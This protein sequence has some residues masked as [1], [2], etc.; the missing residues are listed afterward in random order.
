[1]GSEEGAKRSRLLSF[2]STLLLHFFDAGKLGLVEGFL[3]R[4]NN[5]SSHLAVNPGLNFD[6]CFF[7]REEGGDKIQSPFSSRSVCEA[8]HKGQK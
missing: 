1:M 3:F 4:E 2:P 5:F 6:F 7:S 8:M